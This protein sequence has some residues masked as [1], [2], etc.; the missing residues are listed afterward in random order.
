MRRINK[1]RRDFGLWFYAHVCQACS[2]LHEILEFLFF[3]LSREKKLAVPSFVKSTIHLSFSINFL[4]NK[5]TF[6]LAC[7]IMSR[8]VRYKYFSWRCVLHYASIRN[9]LISWLITCELAT[10]FNSTH[11]YY[12]RIWTCNPISPIA[13]KIFLHKLSSH[14]VLNNPPITFP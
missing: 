13:L 2:T 10:F 8:L 12:L 1:L 4:K 14:A 5:R 3:M 6:L 9:S 11:K 7:M